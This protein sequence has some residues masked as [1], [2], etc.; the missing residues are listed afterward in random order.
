MSLRRALSA[1][2]DDRDTVTATREVIAFFDRHRSAG[3]DARRVSQA[4]GLS[5]HTVGIV[6]AALAD[7]IV[8]DCDGDPRTA[9]CS[10]APDSVLEIE[11]RRFLKTAAE[12]ESVRR[13]Q[14]GRFRNRYG[15]GR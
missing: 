2:P 1:L 8:I 9:E 5:S 7:A 15:S 10:Y 3:L 6:L 11:V 12:V 13:H 4:T 14:V